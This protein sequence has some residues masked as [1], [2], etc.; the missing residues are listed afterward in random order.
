MRVTRTGETRGC[1]QCDECW[2][3]PE[4]ESPTNWENYSDEDIIYDKIH[5]YCEG[6][7]LLKAGLGGE[8]QMGHACMGY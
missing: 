5:D 4:L 7:E 8:N 6:C 2:D 1:K 3:M